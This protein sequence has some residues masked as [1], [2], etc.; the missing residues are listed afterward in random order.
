MDKYWISIS[1]ATMVGALDALESPFWPLFEL[2][3]LDEHRKLPDRAEQRVGRAFP[4]PPSHPP[5]GSARLVEHSE[6]LRV[7]SVNYHLSS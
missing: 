3:T 5:C 7:S 1:K 4:T 2:T 6:L